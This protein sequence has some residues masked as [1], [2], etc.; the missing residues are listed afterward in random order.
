MAAPGNPYVPMD[1]VPPRCFA[2]RKEILARAAEFLSNA[3]KG[4]DAGLLLSGHRGIGK[5][6]A[7]RAVEAMLPTRVPVVRVRFSRSATLATFAQA[8]IGDIRSKIPLWRTWLGV[9]EVELP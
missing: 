9:R 6:S 3:Q 1:A 5:T 2:G 4:F 8:V 7:L